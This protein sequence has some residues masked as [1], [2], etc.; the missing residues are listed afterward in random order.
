M[1]TKV[2]IHW[3]EMLALV[4]VGPVAGSSKWMNS[5]APLTLT[6]SHGTDR[7]SW[8]QDQVPP[9]NSRQNGTGLIAWNVGFRI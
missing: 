3:K 8:V 1:A 2:Q 4:A 6:Q 7:A 9:S 5:T